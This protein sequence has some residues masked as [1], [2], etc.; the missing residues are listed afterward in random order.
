MGSIDQMVQ[1]ME[2]KPLEEKD[3]NDESGEMVDERK[4]TLMEKTKEEKGRGVLVARDPNQRIA[5]KK[6][7]SKGKDKEKRVRN[8][9]YVLCGY[10]WCVIDFR[11]RIASYALE[12]HEEAF[13]A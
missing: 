11:P 5:E 10:N 3:E 8:Q 2:F 13:C 7:E 12:C 4:E 1:E 9:G 6:G